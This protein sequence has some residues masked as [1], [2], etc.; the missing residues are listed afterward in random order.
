MRILAIDPGEKRIGIAVSDPTG[1]IANPLKIMKHQSRAKDAEAIAQ[2][3]SE[4]Q[5]AKIIVGEALNDEGEATLQSQRSN[6]LAE[7]IR[8]LVQIPV[9]M[10]DESGSTK[11]VRAVQIE[12]GVPKHKRRKHI[13]HIAATYILQTYLDWKQNYH[14]TDFSTQSQ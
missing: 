10:W 11:A 9:E 12:M 3:A 7:A 6:R 5:A 1:T 8:K 13:D 4:Y 2:L 14:P